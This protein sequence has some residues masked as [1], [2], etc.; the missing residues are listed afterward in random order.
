MED[1]FLVIFHLTLAALEECGRL[2]KGDTVL[3]TAAAGGTGQF[4]VQLAALAGCH[5]IATAGGPDKVA[6]LRRLGAHRV[7]DYK[8]ED[9]KV[10]SVEQQSSPLVSPICKFQLVQYSMCQTKHFKTCEPC[11]H[12]TLFTRLFECAVNQYGAMPVS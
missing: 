7:V 1:Y 2:K 9:L 12:I 6:F 11:R 5:V 10:R 3:V 4:A 8:S